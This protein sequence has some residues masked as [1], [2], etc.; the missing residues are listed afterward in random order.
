MRSKKRHHA[1]PNKSRNPV[2]LTLGVV[3]EPVLM[4]ES[5]AK[6]ISSY[7]RKRQP[8]S[9]SITPLDVIGNIGTRFIEV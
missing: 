1:H 4:L 5:T 2:I 7:R 9:S 3:A 8:P 6:G